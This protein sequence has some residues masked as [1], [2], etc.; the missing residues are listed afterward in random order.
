MSS[1]DGNNLSKKISALE[2]SGFSPDEIN[3]V[4]K[5]LGTVAR[6]ADNDIYVE[7]LGS[8][9]LN[10]ALPSILV[11]GTGALFFLLTGGEDEPAIT[12]ERPCDSDSA[13]AITQESNYF[14]EEGI[15]VDDDGLNQSLGRNNRSASAQNDSAASGESKSSQNTGRVRNSRG[16]NELPF[17]DPS[18]YIAEDD[19]EYGRKLDNLYSEASEQLLKEVS[20]SKITACMVLP[21]F[22]ECLSPTCNVVFSDSYFKL[23]FPATCHDYNHSCRR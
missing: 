22:V 5:R 6:V 17:R 2:S 7:T 10:Y 15:N 14:Q 8:W 12:A 13:I 16:S 3:E 18:L 23:F 4:L 1:S 19:N 21:R 11:L 20:K 9:M